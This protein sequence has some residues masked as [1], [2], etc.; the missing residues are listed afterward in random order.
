MKFSTSLFT[1]LFAS[2]HLHYI[3]LIQ[4]YR[5]PPVTKHLVCLLSH[6][7][8]TLIILQPSQSSHLLSFLFLH[9][10][11]R[12]YLNLCLYLHPPPQLHSLITHSLP[13]H[14]P[15]LCVPQLNPNHRIPRVNQTTEKKESYFQIN[16]IISQKIDFCLYKK[17]LNSVK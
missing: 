1:I 14:H 6:H 12:S 11:H 9:V 5:Q 3:F 13:L 15:H 8:T 2:N 17:V 4:N 16:K 7:F 10:R